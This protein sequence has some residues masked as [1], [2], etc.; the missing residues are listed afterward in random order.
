MLELS[1]PDDVLVSLVKDLECR[2][3]LK[4]C[5]RALVPPV[6][7]NIFQVIEVKA[8]SVGV[9]GVV[10]GQFVIF[11]LDR[12]AIETEVVYDTLKALLTHKSNVVSIEELE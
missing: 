12:D 1:N 3:G 7:D 6:A 10:L 8:C 9:L 5:P 4:C 11:L 2:F